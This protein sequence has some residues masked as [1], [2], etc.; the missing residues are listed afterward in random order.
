VPTGKLSGEG[1]KLWEEIYQKAKKG[2]CK[3]DE[4]CAARTAWHGIENAGWKRDKEGNW[5]KSEVFTEFS[6]R[7][8]RASYDK[9]T[10]ER[11]VRIVASDTD[12]DNRGD[13]M[14]L[15]LFND[16]IDRIKK[17]EPVPKEFQSEFWKSG[18]PY[19]SVSHYP[20]SNGKTVPGIIDATYIDGNYL[21]SKGKFNDTLLGR[22]C[23]EAICSDLYGDTKD[24]E[25]KI[26]VSIAFLDYMHKHKS[27]GFVFDRKTAKT[28]YCPECIKE[29]LI[30]E[31]E[32][33]IF[34]RGQLIHEAL[35]R[36]PVNTRTSMEVDKSMADKILTRKDDAKSIVGDDLAE[37]LE[38]Q[39]ELI[40]KSDALVYRSEEE[41]VEEAMVEAP[42]VEPDKE[43]VDPVT[44]EEDLDCTAKKTGE[45]ED[46][47]VTKTEVE[48]PEISQD[49]K[50]LIV[51]TI[52]S[53]I[54]ETKETIVETPT[55]THPLD[56]YFSEFKQK[57]DEI[58]VSDADEDEKLRQVQEPFT[59]LGNGIVSVVKSSIKPQEVTPE[60]Q[61]QMDIVAALSQ[62]MNPIAQKLDL[63]ITQLSTPQVER[64]VIPVP[65]RRSIQPA[66]VQQYIQQ[67]PVIKSETPNLRK[68][69]ERTT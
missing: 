13:S 5:H 49:I 1:K 51:E 4:E 59:S 52:K 35:T 68:I 53:T 10:G 45:I 27:N 17:N 34:L 63:V 40:G 15:E 36:V 9:A 39:A 66:P 3:G 56:N 26:R 2:S 7:I 62:V 19:I 30:G 37:E 58:V 44:G 38:E 20:D 28:A 33:K 69:I 42:T 22:K 25:D 8:D 32:G 54:K 29:I 47:E 12:E 31:G 57:F 18:E 64:P 6:M 11:R 67:Q 55:S 24:R 61:G 43:C 41:V 65:P 14:S 23:F 46:S 48:K 16:F 21:K 50:N 60:L